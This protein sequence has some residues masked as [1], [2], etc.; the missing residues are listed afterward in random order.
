LIEMPKKIPSIGCSTREA[1]RLR[2]I[3]E[4]DTNAEGKT[5]HSSQSSWWYKK[6]PHLGTTLKSNI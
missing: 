3:R 6:C 1:K 4:N 5:N 2:S